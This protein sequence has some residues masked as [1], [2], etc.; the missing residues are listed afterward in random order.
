[1]SEPDDF[2]PEIRLGLIALPIVCSNFCTDPDTGENPVMDA[3]RGVVAEVLRHQHQQ[4]GEAAQLICNQAG[5]VLRDVS[6][7]ELNFA[8]QEAAKVGIRYE[9]INV[10]KEVY[11]NVVPD[12]EGDGAS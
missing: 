1:M 9:D 4:I 10:L 7:E 6:E 8:V 2:V 5:V 3:I 12:N 11:H